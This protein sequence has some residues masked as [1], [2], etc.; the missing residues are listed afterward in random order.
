MCYS[1]KIL[2]TFLAFI[3]I[4]FPNILLAQ[5]GKDGVQTISTPSV[6]VNQ[7]AI[8]QSNVTAGS[9]T[10]TLTNV[11]DL[12]N[13]TPLQIGDLLLII[14]MQGASI[15]NTNTINYGNILSY[16]GAGNYDLPT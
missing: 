3:Y 6:I 8:L 16:N 9:T 10:I 1:Y 11:A 7:Y 15:D 5:F 2:S 4:V 14:Q 13:P 12:N